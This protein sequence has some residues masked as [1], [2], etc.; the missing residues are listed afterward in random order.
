MSRVCSGCLAADNAV[1]HAVDAGR[2]NEAERGHREGNRDLA[3]V[4]AGGGVDVRADVL[5]RKVHERK[6]AERNVRRTVEPV[7]REA[8]E[9]ADDLP[10]EGR[11]DRAAEAKLAEATAEAVENVLAA[12]ERRRAEVVARTDA[13]TE[14]GPE[15]GAVDRARE[16][17][18]DRRDAAEAETT[19]RPIAE[20]V[21]A[22]LAGAELTH[23]ELTRAELTR[24]EL[25]RAKLVHRRA[26]RRRELG[27]E[28]AERVTAKGAEE[29]A[30]DRAVHGVVEETVERDVGVREGGVHRLRAPVI[31]YES[32][33]RHDVARRHRAHGSRSV[34]RASSRGVETMDVRGR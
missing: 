19:D 31:R 15:A 23:A 7:E 8:A 9:R 20:L 13:A 28:L 1:V 18:P 24:A 12:D 14:T 3:V 6:A 16:L 17:V 33:T 27:H 26:E 22:E 5:N 30:A 21:H 34:R 29:R 4:N 10:T 25:T 2:R 32:P 11:V